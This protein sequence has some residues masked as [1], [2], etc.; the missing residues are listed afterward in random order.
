M[1]LANAWSPAFKLNSHTILEQEG[2]GIFENC[3][4]DVILSGLCI[5]PHEMKYQLQSAHDFLLKQRNWRLFILRQIANDAV[6]WK[7]KNRFKRLSNEAQDQIILFYDK[8]L[9]ERQLIIGSL[10]TQEHLGDFHELNHLHDI[11]I[12][13]RPISSPWTLRELFYI[14]CHWKLLNNLSPNIRM[15]LIQINCSGSPKRH[16]GEFVELPA[17]TEVDESSLLRQICISK[18]IL[19]RQLHSN[20]SKMNPDPKTIAPQCTIRKTKITGVSTQHPGSPASEAPVMTTITFNVHPSHDTAIRKANLV[21]TVT[22]KPATPGELALRRI[23]KI[24]AAAAQTHNQPSQSAP[25]MSSPLVMQQQ[26]QLQ[27]QAGRAQAP[28]MMIFRP[29]YTSMMNSATPIINSNIH[30]PYPTV[31]QSGAPII[32]GYAFQASQNNNSFTPQQGQT[33]TSLSNPVQ[34][35]LTN[36]QPP[37]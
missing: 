1:K 27:Q 31:I 7:R 18:Q 34:N 12:N 15:T 36:S 2:T 11:S 21:Q 26:T 17:Q 4:R 19:F 23:Q 25:A 24:H 16:P 28:S 3:C 29:T 20:E 32:G 6:E 8:A 30:I 5:N 14:K 33:F 35:P 13:P 9:F 22:G 10:T 37:N